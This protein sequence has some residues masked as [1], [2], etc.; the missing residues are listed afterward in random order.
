MT[1]T[2]IRF[3]PDRQIFTKDARFELDEP[4]RPRPADLVHRPGPR[5]RHPRPARPGAGRGEVPPRR[6]HRGVRA[7]SSPTTSRSPTSCG[8][9]APDTFTE[10]VPLLDDKGHMTPQ[11]VERELTVDVAVRWDTAYDTELRSFVNVIATPKGGTHVS[12]FEAALTKTFNDAMRAAKVLK[13]DDTDVDQGR[14]ARGPDRGGDRAARRAAVRGPDQG[15]PRHAG[16]ADRRAQGR[17]RRAQG[18]PHLH[19]AGRE[20]PGQAGHGEGR[21]RVRRPG[22]RPASTRRPSG[23]RTR[24][25]PRRCRPSSPTA[26]PP[27]S[28]APS[29]SSSRATRRWAPRRLAR[30]S[31]VPGA[32][33][34]P[35]QDPQRPEGH[36]RRHAQE[37]RVRLDHPGR[38]RRLGPH[39]RP[40]GGPLRPDH[41]HGRRRL[42]RRPH[43]LPAG[44]AVLQVH[45][46]ARHATA[47]SSPPCRRCTGSS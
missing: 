22:S 5:A 2:R 14:R 29:C 11:E 30:N 3:W 8:C 6:R 25:S 40:R 37:R 1:G 38:R 19:Q 4:G 31:R 41:L 47:G 23:A 39:L 27:T 42:R 45:A 20:G 43:P 16:R 35:R 7:S 21:R 33:A 12:G 13:A 32:A 44:D 9:R 15:D 28:S 26:A 36:R 24:W 17:G 34:D 10:T 18:V 46:R